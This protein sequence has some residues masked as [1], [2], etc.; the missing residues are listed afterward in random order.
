MGNPRISHWVGLARA[1]LCQPRMSVLRI[2]VF[3]CALLV[4][5]ASTARAELIRVPHGGIT[6][7][8]NPDAE[9]S[10]AW[11][12]QVFGGDHTYELATSAAY[13]TSRP[14]VLPEGATLTVGPGVDAL[15]K[16]GGSSWA[17]GEAVL[18]MTD[19]SA[20]VGRDGDYRSLVVDANLL[21]EIGIDAR[22]TTGASVTDAIVRRTLNAYTT[23]DEDEPHQPHLIHADGSTDFTVDGCLLRNAGYPAA[24]LWSIGNIGRGVSMN[25]S[26]GGRV[27]RSDIAYTMG[28]SIAI[29]HSTHSEIGHNVLQHSG[30]VSGEYYRPYS[31]DSIIGYHSA[32]V[33]DTEDRA[34]YIR[35][36]TILHWHNHGIH[37]SG[38]GLHIDHNHI[39]QGAYRAIYLGDWRTPDTECS[40][41]STI[42]YNYVEHGYRDPNGSSIYVAPYQ[43][44]TVTVRGNTGEVETYYGCSCTP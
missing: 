24:T 37:V 42:T 33:A 30:L 21:A 25:E 32:A 38:K 13:Y 16:A 9:G 22:G 20:I 12:F 26:V 39:A 18:V 27:V 43:H 23:Y 44:G 10:L 11:Y 17:L 31:E 2:A 40:S 8:G 28:A 1:V 19:R 5:S 34:T 4:A 3:A 36:N 6:D 7:H 29:G 41:A 14:F 15:L 35:H